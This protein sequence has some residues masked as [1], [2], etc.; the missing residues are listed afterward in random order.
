[1]SGFTAAGINTTTVTTTQQAPLGFELTVPDGD[2]GLQTWIYVQNKDSAELVVGTVCGRVGSS[3]TYQV[4]RCPTSE[5]TSRVIGCVQTAIPAESY[6]FIL[7]KGV[8]TVLIDT[9]VSANAGLQVGDGTA[10]RA[11]ASGGALTHPT[12]G[13]SLAA[14]GTGETGNAHINCMG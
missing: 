14:I 9:G 10:G 4:L 5:T 3:L 12:F 11:D 8:G 6:G 2:K 13:F 1:M 7:R